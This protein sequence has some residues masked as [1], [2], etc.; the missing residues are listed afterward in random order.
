[1]AA[2][3][4]MVETVHKHSRD[5]ALKVGIWGGI[6]TGVLTLAIGFLFMDV[7]DPLARKA[8]WITLILG[9]VITVIVVIAVLLNDNEQHHY[10]RNLQAEAYKAE[11]DADVEVKKAKADLTKARVEYINEQRRVIGRPVG[12]RVYER[13]ALPTP[14][15]APIYTNDQRDDDPMSDEDALPVEA[16]IE[17]PR[18]DEDDASDVAGETSTDVQTTSTG[19]VIVTE[20]MAERQVRI[21]TLAQRIYEIC[22][23]CDPLTQDA[24]KRRIRMQAGGLLRS[25]QDITD[26]LDLMAERNLVTPSMGKGVARRWTNAVRAEQTARAEADTR[27]RTRVREGAGQ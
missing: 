24:I 9:T 4:D 21:Y 18:D 27:A 11:V 20:S 22:R 26:A 25:N 6:A 17:M 10:R 19:Q 23:D 5:I 14:S 15:N 13:P 7:D 8:H 3:E 12:A 16:E 2:I 1:M